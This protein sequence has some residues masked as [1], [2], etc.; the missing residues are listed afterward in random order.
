MCR[1]HPTQLILIFSISVLNLGQA[2]DDEG[3][4]SPALAKDGLNSLAEECG[5]PYT[6]LGVFE[7]ISPTSKYMQFRSMVESD[8]SFTAMDARSICNTIPHLEQ[9]EVTSMRDSESIEKNMF[10][11]VWLGTNHKQKTGDF[12]GTDGSRITFQSFVGGDEK[13]VLLKSE[14]GFLRMEDASC[15]SI[16]AGVLC[17]FKRG[18]TC[19]YQSV[20]ETTAPE[21]D[22][23]EGLGGDGRFFIGYKQKNWLE[24]HEFCLSKGKHLLTLDA[25]DPIQDIADAIKKRLEERRLHP[26]TQFWTAGVFQD[27][28]YQQM[29]WKIGEEDMVPVLE[30]VP[31]EW[32]AAGEDMVEPMDQ[33]NSEM[34]ICLDISFE[35]SALNSYGSYA[36]LWRVSNCIMPKFF[37]CETVEYGVPLNSLMNDVPEEEE[38]TGKTILTCDDAKIDP[39]NFEVDITK[40]TDGDDLVKMIIFNIENDLKS[41]LVQLELKPEVQWKEEVVDLL[42]KIGKKSMSTDYVDHGLLNVAKIINLMYLNAAANENSTVNEETWKKLYIPHFRECLDNV[43]KIPVNGAGFEI[44]QIEL[45][46]DDIKTPYPILVPEEDADTVKGLDS[47]IDILWFLFSLSFAQCYVERPENAGLINFASDLL[48]MFILDFVDPLREKWVINVDTEHDQ[49]PD[50]V[51]YTLAFGDVDFD[52]AKGNLRHYVSAAYMQAGLRSQELVRPLDTLSLFHDIADRHENAKTGDKMERLIFVLRFFVVQILITLICVNR[53][54][55]SKDLI[56]DADDF[57]YRSCRIPYMGGKVPKSVPRQLSQ[58][59]RNSKYFILKGNNKVPVKHVKDACETLDLQPAEIRN[60]YEL[61]TISNYLNW[62]APSKTVVSLGINDNKREGAFVESD[63]TPM[64]YHSFAEGQPDNHM[65]MESCV[66]LLRHP[67]VRRWVYMDVNCDMGVTVMCMFKTSDQCYYSSPTSDAKLTTGFQYVGGSKKRDYFLVMEQ[68]PRD[69]AAAECAKAGY[70]LVDFDT[71]LNNNQMLY[72]LVRKWI[73]R[74]G[75]YPRIAFW[76]GGKIVKSSSSDSKKPQYAFEGSG[77][78]LDDLSSSWRSLVWDLDEPS[79]SSGVGLDQCISAILY[80]PYKSNGRNLFHLSTTNCRIPHYSICYKEKNVAFRG[81][82]NDSTSGRDGGPEPP[83]EYCKMEN[84]PIDLAQPGLTYEELIQIAT[85]SRYNNI[86]SDDF[87]FEWT[88]AKEWRNEFINTI[89]AVGMQVCPEDAVPRDFTNTIN[90]LVIL[91][92]NALG[93]TQ[94]PPEA[95]TTRIQTET[96][97]L[98]KCAATASPMEFEMAGGLPISNGGSPVRFPVETLDTETSGYY[99][100]VLDTFWLYYLTAIGACYEQVDGSKTK[101]LM[102]IHQLVVK[103]FLEPTNMPDLIPDF[104]VIVGDIDLDAAVYSLRFSSLAAFTNSNITHFYFPRPLYLETAPGVFIMNEL[105]FN[106]GVFP[107]KK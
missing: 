4:G 102:D 9:A 93:A 47:A 16:Q 28:S 77:K 101:W 20:E 21:P 32:A 82:N 8:V 69:A 6:E 99:D 44:A 106:T 87:R 86:G 39:V 14:D 34:E 74:N 18:T 26:F 73:N 5:S 3:L 2:Q 40:R 97:F 94:D 79:D 107:Y 72:D 43:E 12:R 57:D 105:H 89:F 24:A 41:G 58:M 63:G 10:G 25:N 92:F 22:D 42:V 66:A 96:D 48:V 75:V 65:N 90:N 76:T 56:S 98:K 78:S 31:Q 81:V 46:E 49:G 30:T 35:N 84:V 68:L 70:N 23:L 19:F 64:R 50:V 60:K 11:T 37:I 83:K 36:P 29:Y 17:Q 55:F 80:K 38:E 61:I 62:N 85:A 1:L 7:K 104:G 52:N 67:T 53:S 54:V 33:S 45:L 71:G 51:D 15:H 13:C 100:L 27:L 91:Y 95:V 88:E 59:G 103:H